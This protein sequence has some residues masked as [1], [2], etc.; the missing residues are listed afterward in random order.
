MDEALKPGFYCEK[1]DTYSRPECLPCAI[2]ERDLLRSAVTSYDKALNMAC[3]ALRTI[4]R[5]GG[6]TASARAA[7]ELSSLLPELSRLRAL[8]PDDG[9]GT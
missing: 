6:G 3:G 4:K 7:T 5:F 8:A 9:S 1:H 2:A